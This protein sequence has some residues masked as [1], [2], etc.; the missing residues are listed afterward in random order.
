MRCAENS[1]GQYKTINSLCLPYYENQMSI[2]AHENTNRHISGLIY[3]NILTKNYVKNLYSIYL[4]SI[5]LNLH[6]ISNKSYHILH[7]ITR[8]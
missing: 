4:F 8:S 1:M 3:F 6:I 7:N 2:Q 5:R